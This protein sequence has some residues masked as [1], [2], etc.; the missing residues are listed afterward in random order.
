[1]ITHV[2]EP[3]VFTTSAHLSV[4]GNAAVSCEIQNPTCE[5]KQLGQGLVETTV[6]AFIQL[7]SKGTDSIVIPFVASC[8][9]GFCP[10]NTVAN[11]AQYSNNSNKEN[12]TDDNV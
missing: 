11:V 5:S 3:F 1:M 8:P 9:V 4:P 6:H 7:Q 10:T 2:I 12:A